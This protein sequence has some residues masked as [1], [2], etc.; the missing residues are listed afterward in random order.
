M[1]VTLNAPESVRSIA[2]LRIGNRQRKVKLRQLHEASLQ[3][4]GAEK[5]N[6]ELTLVG[7]GYSCP[8]FSAQF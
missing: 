4:R 5:L 7:F 8:M 3:T 2:Y 6:D 1:A